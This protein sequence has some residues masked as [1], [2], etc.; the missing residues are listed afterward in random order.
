[1][2]AGRDV[3]RLIASW[4]VEEAPGRAPD[5]IL[6]AAGRVIDRTNQRRIVA[7]WREPMYV[8]MRG[9]LAAAVIGA[10]L[11]GG[12]IFFLRGAPA[13]DVGASPTPSLTASATP[14]AASELAAYRVARNAICEAAAALPPVPNAELW[15]F[16]TVYDPNRSAEDRAASIVVGG[17]IADRWEAWVDQLDALTAPP[18]VAAEHIAYVAH[19][20][21]FIQLIRSE[22]VYLADNRVA[23]AKALDGALA[24]VGDDLQEFERKYQLSPCG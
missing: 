8:T 7:E 12:A 14:D 16:D 15:E 5:R 6:D 20:R 23:E 22:L 17:A 10:V 9:L 4:L 3:E 13:T 11:V 1:M 21:D 24:P 18:Q 19:Y 2:N